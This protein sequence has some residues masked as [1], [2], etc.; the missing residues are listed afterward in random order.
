MKGITMTSW[1]YRVI[2]KTCPRTQEV[3]YQIHEVF[4]RADGGIDCWNH[5]PVEPLGTSEAGLRNDIRAF[6]SAFQR[7]ALEEQF[8]H[9]KSLLTALPTTVS[10]DDMR[11]DYADRTSRAADYIDQ[12]LGNPLMLRNEPALRQ[13]FNRV[14]KALSELLDVAVSDQFATIE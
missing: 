10:S 3:T 9:G 11:R 13:A 12:L 5:A 2:K 1:N 7:P 6:L 14:E 8:S 4:Y